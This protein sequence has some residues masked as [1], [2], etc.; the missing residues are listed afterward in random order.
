VPTP[1]PS[2]STSDETLRLAGMALH[3]GVLIIGPTHWAAAIRTKEGVVEHVVRK[4]PV[5]PAGVLDAPL[6][7]G[8]AALAQMIAILPALK[9]AMPQAKLAIEMPSVIG[10][11]AAGAV[12]SR[13]SR[14]R[15]S[16]ALEAGAGLAALGSM[17]F[18]LRTGPLAEYHGAEHKAIG[19]YE[20]GISAAEASKEHERCGTHMAVPMLLTNLAATQLFRRLMPGRPAAANLA[21]SAAGMVLATEFAKRSQDGHDSAVQ[22]LAARVGTGLQS[23]ASTREPSAEQL[24]VAE[25][26]LTAVLQ[27]EARVA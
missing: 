11:M 1:S 22:R 23:V 20:Q 13:L 15:R 14:G 19:G 27:A 25:A 16:A 24:E 2:P 18:T 17:L 8:P 6:L 7:R 21:G 10:S 5:A 9:R 4:R 3:N 12:L 26:A